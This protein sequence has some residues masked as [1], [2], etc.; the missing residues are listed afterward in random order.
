MIGQGCPRPRLATCVFGRN[1]AAPRALGSLQRWI[2]LL[3]AWIRLLVSCTT[4][5]GRQARWRE[6]DT[7]EVLPQ[8]KFDHKALEAYLSQRLPG[9]G[10]QPETTLTVS[11]YR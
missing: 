10:A 3:V 5:M 2:P 7:A 8:H 9:F 4:I 11:Q 6:P 1:P